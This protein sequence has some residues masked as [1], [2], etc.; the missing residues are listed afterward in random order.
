MKKLLTILFFAIAVAVQS[1]AREVYILNNDW[2][3]YFKEE[4]SSDEARYV[5]LPH[6]WNLDALTGDGSSCASTACRAL[7][8]Y[9]SAVAT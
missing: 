4:N 8:T 2:K 6:T 7:P 5:R 9:S 1:Q 3:F